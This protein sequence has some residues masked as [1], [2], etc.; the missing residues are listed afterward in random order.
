[1]LCGV[2]VI[3]VLCCVWCGDA[4]VRAIVLLCV[5][6]WLC[7]VRVCWRVLASLY[8][9]GVV[10]VIVVW[11]VVVCRCVSVRSVVVCF[12]FVRLHV[13]LRVWLPFCSFPFQSV[14]G[15]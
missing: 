2:C 3:G 8:M 10:C 15:S 1:M 9:C 5:L 11:C 4:C 12:V 7:L 14:D 6:L 13:L